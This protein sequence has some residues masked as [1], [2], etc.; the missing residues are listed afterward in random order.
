MRNCP[1]AVMLFCAGRGTRMGALTTHR[2]KPMVEV[3]GR[4]LVDHA[5]AQLADIPTRVA[6]THYLPE[7]LEAHLARRGVQTL[8]E[9]Q[10]LETGGGLKHAA[11][12]FSHEAVFTMNTDAVW[13]GGTA[14]KTLVEAWDPDRMDALLLT[15]PLS[16][17]HGHMGS[18]DFERSPDGQLARG[19]D[20]VYTGFQIIKLAPVMAVPEA[21]FSMNVVWNA[22]HAQARLFGAV[23]DGAWCDV[24][25]PEGIEIAETALKDHGYV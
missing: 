16:R 4:P 1:D 7:A 11:A 10:L 12:Q 14:V 15:V 24:G 18:G 21:V 9:P 22:L 5:L 20:L 25:H 6:N 23:F 19:G 3:A 17:T 13:L 2:P 8:F